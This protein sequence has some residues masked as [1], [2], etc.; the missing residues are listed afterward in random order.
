[1]QTSTTIGITFSFRGRFGCSARCPGA[2]W[3]IL[4]AG[5]ERT[6]RAD[7]TVKHL[8]LLV[9]KQEHASEIVL[10]W[11]PRPEATQPPGTLSESG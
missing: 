5:K 6:H 3:S 2:E 7:Q 10:S 1:M 9:Q 4:V 8:G 11:R